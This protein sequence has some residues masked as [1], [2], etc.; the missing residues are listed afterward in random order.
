MSAFEKLFRTDIT[1]LGG[2]GLH[3]EVV[4]VRAKSFTIKN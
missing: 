4:N 3:S 2:G 1:V